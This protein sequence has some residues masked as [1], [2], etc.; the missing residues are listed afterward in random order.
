MKQQSNE[1]LN[2]LQKGLNDLNRLNDLNETKQ[3][4]TNQ[5]KKKQTKTKQKETNQNETL[6]E[7][8][9]QLNELIQIM[10]H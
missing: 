8:K 3:N 2:L 9:Q 6:K 10:K 1:F 4:E 5:N 7:L